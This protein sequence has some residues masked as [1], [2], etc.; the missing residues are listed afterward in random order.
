VCVW[1][2]GIIMKPYTTANALVETINKHVLKRRTLKTQI[3]SPH[4]WIK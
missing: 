1:G 2:G 3:M 4:P